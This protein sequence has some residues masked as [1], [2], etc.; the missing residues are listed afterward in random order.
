MSAFVVSEQHI[1]AIVS[2]AVSGP[3]D[4]ESQ[5]HGISWS[6]E[7]EPESTSTVR[8]MR[9]ATA[10]L[11]ELRKSDKEITADEFGAILWAEN[12]LS[13]RYRYPD[14][15]PDSLPGTVGDDGRG[16]WSVPYRY[17]WPHNQR[18]PTAVEALKLLLCLEYQSCEHPEWRQSEAFRICEALKDS[19]IGALP[20]YSA[21]PWEW[22]PVGAL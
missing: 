7:C 13:V 2:V 4:A 22:D 21:A 3:S 18:R 6:R 16:E 15:D 11:A 8:W 10:G 20:G 12:V 14:E 9:L 1:T 17:T 19:I 5:W